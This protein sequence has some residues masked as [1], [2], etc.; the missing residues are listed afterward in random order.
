M[1]I[2][3]S[4]V[5]VSIFLFLLYCAFQVHKRRKPVAPQVKGPTQRHM[6]DGHL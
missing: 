2:A 5:G 6:E 3:V 1:E 4:L